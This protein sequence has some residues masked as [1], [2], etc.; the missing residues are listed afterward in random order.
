MGRNW[1]KPQGGEEGF[2]EGLGRLDGFR[3]EAP[4]NPGRPALGRAPGRPLTCVGGRRL[5]ALEAHRGAPPAPLPADPA[6]LRGP[7]RG[8]GGRRCVT[9]AQTLGPGL[10]HAFS[11]LRRGRPSRAEFQSSG[12]R[13][14]WVR[15]GVRD[16]R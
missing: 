10:A 1:E 6:L 9:L 4:G 15:A 13:A 12:V 2:E 16:C 11:G 8:G 5:L 3:D 14:G 7:V